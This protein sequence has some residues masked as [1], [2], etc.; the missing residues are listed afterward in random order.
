MLLGRPAAKKGLSRTPG[1][2]LFC[3]LLNKKLDPPLRCP[4][5]CNSLQALGYQ[6]TTEEQ[7]QQPSNQRVM[8][9]MIS[10]YLSQIM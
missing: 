4:A 8:I 9:S 1:M 5:V 7:G 2:P 10:R 3:A 6:E